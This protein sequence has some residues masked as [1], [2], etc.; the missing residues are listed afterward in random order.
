[1]RRRQY[2]GVSSP[3]TGRRFHPATPDRKL[4]YKFRLGKKLIYLGVNQST[5]RVSSEGI[6][7]SDAEPEPPFFAGAWAGSAPG[8][9]LTKLVNYSI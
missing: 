9:K 2:A 8:V 6:Q 4:N 3:P 7:N 5:S 1:M